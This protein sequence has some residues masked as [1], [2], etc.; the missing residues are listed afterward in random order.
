MIVDAVGWCTRFIVRRLGLIG[1]KGLQGIF[2]NRKNDSFG[3]FRSSRIVTTD[4][5]RTLPDFKLKSGIDGTSDG[6]RFG[7]TSEGDVF[8]AELTDGV[9]GSSLLATGG[10]SKQKEKE[11]YIGFHIYLS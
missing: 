3:K 9:I 11:V 1:S 5:L 10:C 6:K 8:Y 4:T 7:I 2:T